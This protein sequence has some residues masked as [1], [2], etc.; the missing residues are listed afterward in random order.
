MAAVRGLSKWV[1]GIGARPRTTWRRGRPSG[2]PYGK[3]GVPYPGLCIPQASL[4]MAEAIRLPTYDGFGRL[5]RT[6]RGRT[7]V[8]VDGVHTRLFGLILRMLFEV[9]MVLWK[10]LLLI[11][12]T[13]FAIAA[14]IMALIPKDTGGERPVAVLASTVR[15]ITRYTMAEED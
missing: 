3:V 10:A 7:A 12:H 1:M 11:G 4:N 6:Y 13:P 9:L 14:I 8:G 2:I 15:L 5:A